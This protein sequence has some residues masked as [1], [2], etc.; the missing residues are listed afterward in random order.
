MSYLIDG[1]DDGRFAF[2][3]KVH[4]T[5]IDGVAGFRMISDALSRRSMLIRRESGCGGGE[6]N[7]PQWVDRAKVI[8]WPE[9]PYE[10][11]KTALSAKYRRRYGWLPIANYVKFNL[12]PSPLAEGRGEG[13]SARNTG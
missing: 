13:G 4:H 1:L 8:W 6:L 7:D 2:Y 10:S 3:I 9:R 11:R 12:A 5:V